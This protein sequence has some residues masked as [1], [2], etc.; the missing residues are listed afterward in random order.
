[1][2]VN[3]N[4]TIRYADVDLEYER[5]LAGTAPE[6][7]GPV[8][9]VNLM[10]YRPVAEYADGRASTLSGEEADDTYA[11]FEAFAEVGAELVFLA[12]V[13]MQLLGDHPQWDRVAVVKYPTG[14][15]FV[16]M[17]QLPAFESKHVHKDAG[18]ERTIVIG[19]RPRPW[20]EAPGQPE[21]TE[22]PHPPTGDD[23]PIVVLHVLRF[24]EGPAGSTMAR[25]EDAAGSVAV[26]HGVRIAGWLAA[27]GTILGDGRSWDE[28]RFNAF[29]SRAAFFAVAADPDRVAAEAAFR[30]TAV[31]DTYSLLLR[32]MIDRLQESFTA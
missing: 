32:P 15:A 2:A 11:P 9:M 24:H 22:V 4:L 28:V 23:P 8:W 20:P 18:M 30:S 16:D 13:E 14:R 21:W 10:K 27:E 5:V 12:E 19:A 31:A 6:D 17:T 25:Y 1:M 3:P 29:P 26:P 7:D